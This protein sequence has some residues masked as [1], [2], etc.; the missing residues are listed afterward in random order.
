M[1]R[2]LKVLPNSGCTVYR[3]GSCSTAVEQT[4]DCD[5]LR[6]SLPEISAIEYRESHQPLTFKWCA[7]RRSEGN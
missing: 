2:A 6:S 5:T 4:E 7:P 3:D 1:A